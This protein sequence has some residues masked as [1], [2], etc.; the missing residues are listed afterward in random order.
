MKVNYSSQKADVR[1][2][3]L[4]LIDVVFC[5]LTFFM[6]AA[7]TLTRQSG[8]NVDLPT[9]S[10][11]VTQMQEMLLVS[12][13]PVGL[14]YV[15]KDPVTEEDLRQRLTEFQAAQPNG[16]IVL[17][18]SRLS[19]YNDVVRVLDILRA[20]GGDRVALATLPSTSDDASDAPFSF[21]SDPSGL[22][23]SDGLTDPGAQP[24]PGFD[25]PLL[26]PAGNGNS[27]GSSGF[28]SPDN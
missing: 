22:P 20:V 7:V 13:D 23:N 10:S 25:D 17:Y 15:E 28:G 27:P 8:I 4:P 16:T 5:I 24:F 18:A 11:G 3:L 14:I 19:S 6:L 21:P 2:E 12:V 9:A 26:P 1:I